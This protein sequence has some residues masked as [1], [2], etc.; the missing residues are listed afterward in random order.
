MFYT[1][2]P[3]LEYKRSRGHRCRSAGRIQNLVEDAFN[4][5]SVTSRSAYTT[6]THHVIAN[7]AH[8]CV[9]FAFNKKVLLV[10]LLISA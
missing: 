1:P 5:N 6:N 2:T 8:Q 4:A 10:P 7:Y 9:S 3:V